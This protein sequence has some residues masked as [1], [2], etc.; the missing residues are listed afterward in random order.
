MFLVPGGEL[1]QLRAVLQKSL[2]WRLLRKQHRSDSVHDAIFFPPVSRLFVTQDE[3]DAPAFRTDDCVDS[4]QLQLLIALAQVEVP[5]LQ[6]V[7]ISQQSQRDFVLRRRL[8]V[9]RLG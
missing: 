8:V 6:L 7:E 3:F 1:F 5:W 4:C 2:A 9:S